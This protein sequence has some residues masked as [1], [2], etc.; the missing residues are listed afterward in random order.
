MNG[1]S[2]NPLAADYLRRALKKLAAATIACGTLMLTGCELGGMV[3]S[4]I[5]AKAREYFPTAEV[6]HPTKNVLQIDTRLS[7]TEKFAAK[8]MGELIRQNLQEL[9][10]LPLAGYSVLV[11]GFDGG[12]C[13]WYAQRPTYFGCNVDADQIVRWYS[14]DGL[15]LRGYYR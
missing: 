14:L 12:T 10:F 11:F 4:K 13:G 8:V 6:V 7:I 3:D 5:E 1:K 2:H 9:K 15:P